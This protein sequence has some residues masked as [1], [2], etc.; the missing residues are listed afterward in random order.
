MQLPV[1]S[2]LAKELLTGVQVFHMLDESLLHETMATGRLQESTT[3]RLLKEIECAR[4]GGASAVMV[5]CSSLGPAVEVAQ[6][7]FDFP[8]LR[9]DQAMAAAAVRAGRHVGVLATVSTTLGP[10]SDLVRAAAQAMQQ[11]CEI[12]SGLCTGAYEAIAAGN[13]AEHDRLVTAGLRDLMTKVDVVVLAQASMARVLASIPADQLTVP[14]LSSP[15]LG[16]EYAKQVLA[17]QSRATT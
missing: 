4:E 6:E 14:V 10:T 11:E 1:F 15:R 13:G 16:V 17:I 3:R 8:V 12:I 5:T 2:E 7:T 9:V